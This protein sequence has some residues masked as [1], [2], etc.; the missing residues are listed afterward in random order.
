MDIRDVRTDLNPV[1]DLRGIKLPKV[2]YS[3]KDSDMDY[4]KMAYRVFHDK[5]GALITIKNV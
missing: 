3:A 5:N 4:R 2:I 1:I